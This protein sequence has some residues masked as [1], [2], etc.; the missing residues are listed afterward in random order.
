MSI[1][2]GFA[3]MRV[4]NNTLSFSPCLPKAWDKLSFKINFRGYIY[5]LVL[6]QNSFYCE[7]D[8][9]NEKTLIV[10]GTTHMFAKDISLEL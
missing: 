10:N 7:V 4:Q 3:G 8:S 6:L 1:V 5:S 9:A 2:E